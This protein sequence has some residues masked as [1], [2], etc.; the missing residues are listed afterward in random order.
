MP[1]VQGYQD[2]QVWQKAMDLVLE[3]YRV[4]GNLPKAE[5]FGLTSQMQRAAVS[6]PANIAE[7]HGRSA[8]SAFLNHL[9]IAHGSLVELETH[10]QIADRLGYLEG[11]DLQ[12][13][14]PRTQEVGRMLRGL[15]RSLRTKNSRADDPAP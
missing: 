13:F 15:I 7:G 10:V 6:I 4:A 14:L 2:L 1:S 11:A 3:A 5:Q 9:S 12:S 8:T